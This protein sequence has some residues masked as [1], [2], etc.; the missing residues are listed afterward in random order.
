MLCVDGEAQ[1]ETV[2][3]VIV[4][5]VRMLGVVPGVPVSR[6]NTMRH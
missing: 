5:C 3:H 4:Q 2:T 1:V 6:V